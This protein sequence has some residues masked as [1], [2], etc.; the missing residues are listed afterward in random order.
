[1]LQ[2]ESGKEN[3]SHEYVV[4]KLKYS[5]VLSS[6]RPKIGYFKGD[7]NNDHFSNKIE[8]ETKFSTQCKK[9]H[10]H[11]LFGSQDIAVPIIYMGDAIFQT[12]DL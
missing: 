4:P 12:N 8:K 9:P 5:D 11:S 1:M 7:D 2:V 10:L 6:F 3:L